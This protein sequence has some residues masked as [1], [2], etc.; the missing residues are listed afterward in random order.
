MCWNHQLVKHHC[1]HLFLFDFGGFVDFHPTDLK[2][3]KFGAPWF[4]GFDPEIVGSQ[5]I[6]TESKKNVQ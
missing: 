1:D 3:L 4:Q 6:K 5:K 2:A